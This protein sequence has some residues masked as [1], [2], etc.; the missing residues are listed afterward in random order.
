[1]APPLALAYKGRKHHGT[2]EIE[3]DGLKTLVTLIGIVAFAALVACLMCC[4]KIMDRRSPS[5]PPSRRV[6]RDYFDPDP[7]PY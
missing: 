3:N 2:T 1:M 5:P 4:A 7:P 6:N